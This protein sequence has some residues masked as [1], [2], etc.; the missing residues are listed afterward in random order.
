LVWAKFDPRGTGFI[1]MQ[2][3]ND[4][5]SEVDPPIGYK[6]SKRT[7]IKVEKYLKSKIIPTYNDGKD[8]HFY[9]IAKLLS[10][11]KYESKHTEGDFETDDA[12]F[13]ILRDKSN[14][15]Y[16]ELASGQKIFRSPF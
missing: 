7:K 8:Y 5:L 13:K 3:L 15:Q 12:V 16:P 10:I 1:P 9:E 2:A 4:F 11:R 6:N 14:R